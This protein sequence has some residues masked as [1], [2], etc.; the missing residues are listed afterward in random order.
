MSNNCLKTQL[1]VSVNNPDLIKVGA[2][3]FGIPSNTTT[4]AWVPNFTALREGSVISVV[5]GSATAT[6]NG[7]SVILPYT[8]TGTSSDSAGIVLTSGNEGAVIEFSNKYIVSNLQFLNKC[9]GFNLHELKYNT[10]VA[11]SFPQCTSINEKIVGTLDDII[12]DTDLKGG[13]YCIVAN[14]PNLTGDVRTFARI[15][16]FTG[17]N[18]YQSGVTGRI[19]DLVADLRESDRD[20]EDQTIGTQITFRYPRQTK[21]TFNGNEVNISKDEV[22]LS[23][24]DNTITLDDVTIDA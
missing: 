1:K 5:S 15:M 11:Q 21:V 13:I 18:V 19:E 2:M 7:S 4:T 20:T 14:L 9:T 17:L 16:N 24:T 3:R 10:V 8:F 6:I 23:W 12:K 22:T